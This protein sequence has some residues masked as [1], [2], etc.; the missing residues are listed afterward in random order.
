MSTRNRINENFLNLNKMEEMEE[1]KEQKEKISFDTFLE[2]EKKLEIKIGKVVTAEEVPK[3]SKLIKMTVSFG[4]NDNRTVVTNIKPKLGEYWNEKLVGNKFMFI[5][6]LKPVM[7]MGIEST[8]M[9]VPGELNDEL[10]T[11]SGK[12]GELM[13]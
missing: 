8:A 3:S 10:V 11:V 2:L 12:E 7:M 6:N 5:T 9:I 1:I 4:Y 13:L